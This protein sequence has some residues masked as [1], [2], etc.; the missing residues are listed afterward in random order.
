M[1]VEIKPYAFIDKAGKKITR[2]GTLVGKAYGFFYCNS[3]KQ[4]IEALLSTVR[5]LAQTPSQLELSL[6]QDMNSVDCK[7]LKSLAQEARGYGN[8]YLLQAT[9]PNATNMDTANELSSIL[10]Q[11]YQSPL[12]ESGEEFMGAIVYEERGKYVFRE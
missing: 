9:F 5:E 10:Y 3:P 1:K 11:A 6:T 8:N 4:E 7:E 12:Y 2:E